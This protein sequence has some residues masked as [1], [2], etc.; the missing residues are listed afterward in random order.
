MLSSRVNSLVYELDESFK[1][2]GLKNYL[3]QVSKILNFI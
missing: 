1:Y 3:N 2:K